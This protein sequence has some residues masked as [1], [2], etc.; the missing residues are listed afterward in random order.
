VTVLVNNVTFGK[1]SLQGT[2]I[3][4]AE[5]W[6]SPASMLGEVDPTPTDEFHHVCFSWE[7][8]LGIQGYCAHASELSTFSGDYRL[9]LIF[10][11]VGKV[12][13]S[14]AGRQ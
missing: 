10:F 5:R 8:T 2:R 1:E 9:S 7:H 4:H 3:C 14:M 13:Y 6:P 11:H 12:T